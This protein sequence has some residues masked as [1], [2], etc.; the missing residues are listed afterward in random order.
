[1]S[2]NNQPSQEMKLANMPIARRAAVLEQ[3]RTAKMARSAHAYV[4]GNTAKFYKWL[5]AMPV[6]ARVPAGPAIL[7]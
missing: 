4:R 7:R 1:M 2:E 5:A 3:A 6:A